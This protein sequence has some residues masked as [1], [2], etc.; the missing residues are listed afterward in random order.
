MNENNFFK[1]IKIRNT[2][3]Y[4]KNKGFLRSN[5]LRNLKKLKNQQIKNK[6]L[7]NYSV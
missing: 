1:K 6:F 7:I 2:I 5:N 3:Y 4:Q